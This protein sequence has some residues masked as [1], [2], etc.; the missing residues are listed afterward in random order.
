MSTDRKWPSS[1]LQSRIPLSQALV[2]ITMLAYARDM[3]L[4]GSKVIALGEG[5]CD[6]A[7]PDIDQYDAYSDKDKQGTYGASSPVGD[8]SGETTK[9]GVY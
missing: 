3:T 9:D 5:V 2:S 1:L 7:S 4:T 6:L 8:R